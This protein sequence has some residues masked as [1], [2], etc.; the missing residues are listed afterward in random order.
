VSLLRPTAAKSVAET[1]RVCWTSGAQTALVDVLGVGFALWGTGGAGGVG[2]W[3]ATLWLNV[4]CA[5]RI[6]ATTLAASL[7]RS[8]TDSP[9]E[10]CNENVRLLETIE[11]RNG[12][13]DEC[14]ARMICGRLRSVDTCLFLR[15]AAKRLEMKRFDGGDF[16]SSKEE[17]VLRSVPN[18]FVGSS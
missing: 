3:A 17:I 7:N 14:L 16:L 2:I 13:K 10:S 4:T 15:V 8:F 1:L 9:F 11:Q 5:E 6:I 18:L 12:T